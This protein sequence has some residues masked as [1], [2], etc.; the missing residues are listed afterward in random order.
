[1]HSA[2]I[3]YKS[4]FR[5]LSLLLG[6]LAFGCKGHI[7]LAQGTSA[8]SYQGQLN[9]AG[10]PATGTFDM[11]F[12]IFNNTTG[13]SIT[14]GPLT[15]SVVGVTNGLFNVALDCGSNVF[16]GNALW[17]EI[18]VRPSG[19]NVSYTTLTPRQPLLP[20]PYAL[21][22]MTP[23]GPAGP[24]GPPGND[25]APGPQGLQGPAGP[26]GPEGPSGT[27]DVS[28]VDTI[29]QM[30]V[31][32][33]SGTFVVPT[34]VTKIMVE[35]WGGG[36]GGGNAASNN[37]GP[38]EGGNGGAGG[39]GKGM[40]YVTNGASYPV[41]VGTGGASASAGGTSS[42]G[43]LIYANGGNPGGNG[44]TA[45]GDG[46]TGGNSNGALNITGGSGDSTFSYYL[47]GHGGA[48]G[49]GG[50]GG[51]F[52]YSNTNASVV[53]GFPGNAPGGG[54]GGGSQRYNSSLGTY[55]VGK[56]G[57]GGEGCVIVYW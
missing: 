57:E 16:N 30:Q 3:K 36:G 20:A 41:T 14:G 4:P 45:S 37:V 29:P 19:S 31:F 50:A 24:Q 8:F 55:F 39:Y 17:L 38:Y 23:A 10:S 52:G 32:T 53:N 47:I 40:F 27:N 11:I 1:M 25:G 12:T 28:S 42:F 21:F 9:S 46:G 2:A 49:C 43:S 15:N 22:A 7:L 51:A 34:N 48:A 56:G 13:G 54:G 26:A 18:G 33:N 5:V 6:V 44:I 35:V